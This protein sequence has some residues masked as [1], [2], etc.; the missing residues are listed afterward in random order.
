M[1]ADSYRMHAITLHSDRLARSRFP[2]GNACN[3]KKKYCTRT[4]LETI[5][6]N[7]EVAHRR[8][9]VLLVLVASW[10]ISILRLNLSS[11]AQLTRATT[12]RAQ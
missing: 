2:N 3:Y 5:E 7:V 10:F 1:S 12:T 4:R 9:G 8:R 11:N 6:Q